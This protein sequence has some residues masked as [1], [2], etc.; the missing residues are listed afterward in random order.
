MRFLIRLILW[1]CPSR[2][3]Q[4]DQTAWRQVHEPLAPDFVP[5]AELQFTNNAHPHVIA[6][7]N[8]CYRL[9][10]AGEKNRLRP[11]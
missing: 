8:A 6:H 1:F 3:D 5:D 2:Y 9:P 7:F 10:A 4:P 11:D